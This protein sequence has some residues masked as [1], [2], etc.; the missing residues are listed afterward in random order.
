MLSNNDGCFVSRSNELKA[1]GVGMGEPLFKVRDIIER[2]KV[3]VFSA[4]FA[5][6]GDISWRITE[7]LRRFCP[8]LRFILST[9]R[10]WTLV[11]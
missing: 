7:V 1:L 9:S 11:A 4:N 8:T 6:Y 5:L 3:T 2:N 10:F